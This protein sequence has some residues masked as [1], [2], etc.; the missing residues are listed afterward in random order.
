MAKKYGS[1]ERTT[2][3]AMKLFSFGRHLEQNSNEERDGRKRERASERAGAS[4][5]LLPAGVCET[6]C[7]PR[8]TVEE[9]PRG[10]WVARAAHGWP[11]RGANFFF[12]GR[13]RDCGPD[14]MEARESD[15]HR[16]LSVP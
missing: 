6:D 4:P 12:R 5:S 14:A 15:T 7:G 16:F 11:R 13:E 1:L 8:H 9:R 3:V 2:A 10:G